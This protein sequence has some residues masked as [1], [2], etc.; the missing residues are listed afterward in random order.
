MIDYA[1]LFRK[2]SRHACDHV[3]L[4]AHK[5]IFV[6]CAHFFEFFHNFS[7]VRES[8]DI[9]F[10]PNSRLLLTIDRMSSIKPQE[11]RP[12]P[13]FSL[14]IRESIPPSEDNKDWVPHVCIASTGTVFVQPRL[15]LVHFLIVLS[16]I[17]HLEYVQS[18]LLYR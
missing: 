2:R 5:K 6:G 8:I 16:R 13:M 4:G 3:R 7:R 18:V 1:I 10:L 11:V 9:H 12:E 17:D 14:D 15:A